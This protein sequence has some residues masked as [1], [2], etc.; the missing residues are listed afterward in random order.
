M[1]R[2]KIN[3]LATEGA[4]IFYVELRLRSV[5]SP[6]MSPLMSNKD[7]KP[8]ESGRKIFN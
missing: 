4:S 6:V 7:R 1:P 8:N 2:S 5:I 3:V